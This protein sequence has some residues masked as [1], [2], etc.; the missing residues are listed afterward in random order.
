[1]TTASARP[2]PSGPPP[3]WPIVTEWA[4]LD[5]ARLVRALAGMGF[6][7]LLATARRGDI[8]WWQPEYLRI[9]SARAI[10]EWFP[11]R[12]QDIRDRCIE[13]CRTSW[14]AEAAP[15]NRSIRDAEVWLMLH[16]ATR[17]TAVDTRS[18][19][20]ILDDR[21][22]RGDDLISLGMVRWQC[23]FG[24][25]AHRIARLIDMRG[26]PVLKPVTLDEI[27]KGAALRA[28]AAAEAT[29]DA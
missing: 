21:T 27:F 15:L 28:P 5:P 12:A 4:L 25:A 20:W 10:A 17:I 26:I 29:D 22:Q 1:M 19:E 23:R 6:T 18:G 7:D 8:V 11:P 16:D 3:Y 9:P 2:A 13:D 14:R 24:Q